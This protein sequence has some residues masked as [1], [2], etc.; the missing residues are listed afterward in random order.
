ML[1][2]NPRLAIAGLIAAAAIAV[3]TAALASGS[4]SPPAK[5]APPQASAAGAGK[6]PAPSQLPTPSQLPALAASAGISTDRLQAGLAAMKRAGGNTTA[7]IA[8]FAAT[9]GVSNKTAQQIA[10]AVFGTQAGSG[11]RSRK[12][13]PPQ[14]SG[15]GAG[16]ST[17]A[18]QLPALAA[19]AGISTDRLQAGLAAMKRAGGNTTA[20]IAAFAA[21]AGVSHKTAQQIADAAFGTQAGSK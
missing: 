14:A 12:P 6:S 15:A 11:S 1:A 20:G 18:S 4:G 21:T 8:A 2:R 9:A 17:A 13:A 10:D 5:P 16:K 3:P 19:S 7:G